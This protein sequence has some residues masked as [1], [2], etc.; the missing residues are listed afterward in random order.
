MLGLR[1]SGLP[2]NQGKL[3]GNFGFGVGGLGFRVWELRDILGSPPTSGLL[4]LPEAF[5]AMTC[6]LLLENMMHQ[7]SHA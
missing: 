5:S 2:G 4:L 6:P 3:S 7:T 1:V